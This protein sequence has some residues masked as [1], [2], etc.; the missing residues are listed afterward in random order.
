M[1]TNQQAARLRSDLDG[2]R[3]ELDETNSKLLGSWGIIQDMRHSRSWR[4]TAPIR[5]MKPIFRRR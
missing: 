4:L 5:G 2:V 3:E 1:Q